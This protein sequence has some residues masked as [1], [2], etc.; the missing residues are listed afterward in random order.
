MS[1]RNNEKN[2]VL[3]LVL[4]VLMF[5]SFGISCTSATLIDDED[6]PWFSHR[7]EPFVRPAGPRNEMGTQFNKKTISN[8]EQRFEKVSSLFLQFYKLLKDDQVNE[9]QKSIALKRLNDLSK[10]LVKIF[11]SKPENEMFFNLLLKN[12]KDDDELKPV[13]E[14][15]SDKQ[16]F[17]WGK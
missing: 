1:L 14:K 16:P 10:D 4:V 11:K 5:Y 15:T 9:Y 12:L 17:K 2:G 8:E 7:M 6:S 13:D 3:Y